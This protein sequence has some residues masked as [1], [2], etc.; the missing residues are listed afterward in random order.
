MTIQNVF[1]YALL[2]L[3]E[4]PSWKILSATTD[5]NK[6]VLEDELVNLEL[7]KDAG[8]SVMEPG[9]TCCPVIDE[10]WLILNLENGQSTVNI[11]G[12]VKLAM[13]SGIETPTFSIAGDRMTGFDGSVTQID[14]PTGTHGIC[15]MSAVQIQFSPPLEVSS[16]LLVAKMSDGTWGSISYL[17]KVNVS[18]MQTLPISYRRVATPID[19]CPVTCDATVFWNGDLFISNNHSLSLTIDAYG[20]GSVNISG[21]ANIIGAIVLMV[22]PNVLTEGN[23]YSI[24]E[25]SNHCTNTKVGSIVVYSTDICSSISGTP[26]YSSN[27]NI[28]LLFDVQETCGK[29]NTWWVITAS[30]VGGLLFLAVVF[31]I[32]TVSVP[33][34][35]HKMYPFTM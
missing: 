34:L 29:S 23:T 1:I 32:V 6:Q 12:Q 13:A 35:R 8:C 18:D 33:S 11:T 17:L 19:L 10:I 25:Q 5:W 7:V 24:L 21:C 30:V 31:V 22:D 4:I 3:D 14:F 15:N 20:I 2:D 26:V 16:L 27:G 9:S 28:G